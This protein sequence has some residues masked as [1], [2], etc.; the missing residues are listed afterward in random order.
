M[1]VNVA[2]MKT[3]K[4][5]QILTLNIDDFRRYSTEGITAINPD[6]LLRQ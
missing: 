1:L 3:Y 2:I 6:T 4:I 5:S